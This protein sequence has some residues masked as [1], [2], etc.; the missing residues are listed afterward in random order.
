[1]ADSELLKV[2]A[3]ALA[4]VGFGVLA[5]ALPW[6]KKLQK[7]KP[8]ACAA[9]W[10]GWSSLFVYLVAIAA[11]VYQWDGFAY[12]CLDW[13]VMTGISAWMLSMTG[14]FASLSLED[15]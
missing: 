4:A 10:G 5:R 15:F 11:D 6:P 9:C 12:F 7:R 2:V 13:M 1:M 14:M 3:L 8:W